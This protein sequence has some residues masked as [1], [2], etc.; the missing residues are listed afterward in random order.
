[1]LDPLCD[2]QVIT[3][4][5]VV[6][7]GLTEGENL[8][9]Y[10]QA[11]VADYWWLTINSLF[12][13]VVSTRQAVKAKQYSDFR[14]RFRQAAILVTVALAIVF[15]SLQ[16][17]AVTRHWDWLGSG[18]CYRSLD[19]SESSSLWLWIAGL[20][21]HEATSIAELIF[22]SSGRLLERLEKSHRG[23]EGELVK[24]FKTHMNSAKGHVQN[25]SMGSGFATSL[26]L[27]LSL[28]LAVL[29]MVLVVLSL[30]V[31]QGLAF[32]SFGIGT[33]A[34]QGLFMAAFFLWNFSD[35]VTIKIMNAP[36]LSQ[37][38]SSSKPETWG[39]GQ[40]LPMVLILSVAYMALDAY[41]TV[42]G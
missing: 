26:S 40:T 41:D 22:D 27:L 3:G 15:L 38:N 17:V 35:L 16:A 12:L 34:F 25:F 11:M 10:H 32:W 18:K 13:A 24:T 6:I 4:A 42:W 33:P 29:T 31:R 30:I 20:C 14:L 7:A 2:L 5:G 28:S 39:F 1:M 37:D 23:F 21:L 36:L 9:F 8:S 19:V